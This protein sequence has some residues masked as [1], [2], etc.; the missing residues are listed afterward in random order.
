MDLADRCRVR[1]NDAAGRN[2]HLREILRAVGTGGAEKPVVVTAPREQPTLRG[3]HERTVGIEPEIG[4][5]L[6]APE[7]DGPSRNES[8]GRHA[9]RCRVGPEIAVSVVTPCRHALVLTRHSAAVWR[10]RDRSGNA[11]RRQ[12]DPRG[13]EDGGV[14]A[15]DATVRVG[16]DEAPG[17]HR[18]RCRP[19]QRKTVTGRDLDHIRRR[20][21]TTRRTRGDRCR[22]RDGERGETHVRLGEIPDSRGVDTVNGLHSVEI[23]PDAIDLD[24]VARNDTVTRPER[25]VRIVRCNLPMR[26]VERRRRH[27]HGPHDRRRR[28][29][30][31][32]GVDDPRGVV[33]GQ[34]LGS[35]QQRIDTCNHHRVA[36][37]H[38]V[39]TESEVGVVRRADDLALAHRETG[40]GKSDGSRGRRRGHRHL[41]LEAHRRAAGRR[42][43]DGLRTVDVRRNTA[44]LDGVAHG[45]TVTGTDFDGGDV[46][47]VH[48][49]RRGR[50]RLVHEGDRARGG[51][52]RHRCVPAAGKV[53]GGRADGGDGV[54]AVER[55]L[56]GPRDVDVD[57]IAHLESMVRG[58]SETG[59]GRTRRR[60]GE[61]PVG[62]R[63]TGG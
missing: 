37:S 59:V 41:R 1:Q 23:A 16:A 33:T 61:D 39:C 55:G 45:Q 40:R 51:T 44:D 63:R 4:D 47:S 13:S 58:N 50:E 49:V 8:R 35:V 24:G 56:T 42:C 36:R 6:A 10:G 14:A 7:R 27:G 2:R 17:G 11:P 21:R 46:G 29:V 18:A 28:D 12:R 48:R 54:P 15:A 32:C 57:E 3:E 30:R 19:R 34:S 62:H 53:D 26:H 20:G 31:L 22:S 25:E 52:G 43:R 5:G 9:G 38:V 60:N